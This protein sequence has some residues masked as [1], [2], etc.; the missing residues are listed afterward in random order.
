MRRELEIQFLELS[1]RTWLNRMDEIFNQI[2]QEDADLSNEEFSHS[3]IK[4][5]LNRE[6]SFLTSR[7]Y[8]S[9]LVYFELKELN[10]YSKIFEENYKAV[11][12]TEPNQKLSDLTY[13]DL[14]TDGESRVTKVIKQLLY[15]FRGFGSGDYEHLTG[16][17][18]LES[19]LKSTTLILTN[20]RIVPSQESEDCAGSHI[21]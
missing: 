7:V 10:N 11:I 6:F 20:K 1:I 14:Y 8:N 16:Q 3:E 21:F 18:Y 17:D 5:E 4:K 13:A 9:C 15:P 19:I 2:H 12:K